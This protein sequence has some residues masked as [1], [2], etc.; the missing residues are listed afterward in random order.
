[1]PYF[2]TRNNLKNQQLH[3]EE[4]SPRGRILFAS[5]RSGTGL[6]DL[7][8]AQY[9]ESLAE[10][11][12]EEDLSYLKDLDKQF[13]DTE[14]VV[15]LEADVSGNDIYLFQSILDPN[16]GS[17]ID[18]N[19]IAFLL[20]VRAFREWGANHV[21]AVLPYLAY[22][23][24]DKST[25]FNREPTS[26]RLLADFSIEAGIDRLVTWHPH[27]A[28]IQGFYHRVP[29][30][31]LE[32]YTL[33][34]EVFEKYKGRE[35]VVLVAPD[36][37]ASKFVTHLGRDLDVNSA[38]ASKYRPKPE[39][40]VISEVI[41]D[42]R[43]KRIAIILDD[44][45]SSGGTI[46]NLVKILVEEKGIEKVYI[47]VSHNLCLENARERLI[48]L[49]EGYHLEEVITTNSIPQSQGFR[50][51]D[52]VRE[53]DLSGILCQVINRIHY[54]KPVSELFYSSET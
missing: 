19:Y 3:G 34:R 52:F 16:S 17:S 13:S 25:R 12:V 23:R 36:A 41:G 51:L 9:R 46:Y 5:C 47:G 39:E 7:V 40:A 37:G 53:I 11:G 10:A 4:V 14:N 26:A 20:A 38:I 18:Q 35:E 29:L 2:Y 33:F 31:R 24:Q 22:A 45:I 1:M 50:E 6:A 8:V 43:G 48:E 42:F 30:D 32:S 44:M 27:S 15:R 28:Q 21:T 54:N 49:N